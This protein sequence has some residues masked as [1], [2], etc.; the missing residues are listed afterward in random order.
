MPGFED[1]DRYVEE[2]GIAEGD[3]GEAFAQWLANVAG[4]PIIGGQAGEV[5]TVVAIPDDEEP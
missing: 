3:L 4:G 2:H 5:P 1:F